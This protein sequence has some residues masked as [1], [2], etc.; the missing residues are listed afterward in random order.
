MT[1]VFDIQRVPQGLQNVLNLF[2]P[3]TPPRLAQELV[4]TLD[5]LPFYGLNQR[6]TQIANNAALALAGTLDLTVPANTWAVLFAATVSITK[7]G[8]MTHAR[9][10]LNIQRAAAG[11]FV[12]Y[13]SQDMGPY[14]A[15]L[16]GNANLCFVPSSPILLPP[17][18]VIRGILQGLGTDANANVSVVAELGVFG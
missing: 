5:L 17:M 11:V 14:G 4:G 16:N 13:A 7:T 1:D 8:T 2:G 9:L 6:Q 15:T 12:T 18:S 3:G 10:G